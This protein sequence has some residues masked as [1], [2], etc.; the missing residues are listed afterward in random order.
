V[1]LLRSKPSKWGS[2][3]WETKAAAPTPQ[4]VTVTTK[5]IQ[6]K[7]GTYEIT[8]QGTANFAISLEQ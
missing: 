8:V 4:A 5:P 3:L 1:V 7:A 6:I 2:S